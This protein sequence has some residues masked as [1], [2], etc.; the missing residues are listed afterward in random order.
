MSGAGMCVKFRN[1]TCAGAGVRLGSSRPDTGCI[2]LMWSLPP[3]SVNSNSRREF[4]RG[5]VCVCVKA[6]QHWGHNRGREYPRFKGRLTATLF[7]SQGFIVAKYI[8]LERRSWLWRRHVA[9]RSQPRCLVGAALRAK[10]WCCPAAGRFPVHCGRRRHILGIDRRSCYRQTV[11]WALVS[12]S[13]D[14]G[15]N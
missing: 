4:E 2:L 14:V 12:A 11:S 6:R 15:S 13:R 3:S 8:P 1:G 5:P 7:R 10:G 9:G